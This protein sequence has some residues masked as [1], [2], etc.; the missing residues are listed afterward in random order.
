MQ[1]IY[2]VGVNDG[3][4]TAFYLSQGFRVVGI[5]ANPL[6]AKDLK[7]RFSASI[8]DGSF[9][10]LEIG[11]GRE[12]GEFEFWVCDD[13]S[14][15]S[16]F[17][18]EIASRN[19]ARHHGVVVKTRRFRDV[20]AEHGRAFYCKIDIEGNDRTC[21]ENLP[22]ALAPHYL[23]IEMAHADGIVDL[24][25]LRGLS[26]TRF[27]IISQSSFAQPDRRLS[28]LAFSLPPSARNKFLRIEKALRGVQ[29]QD[30]WEFPYGSSGPFGERTPGRW[31]NFD[32]AAAMWRF[33]HDLD[34]TSGTR[35]IGDWYD[36]HA[37]R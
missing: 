2:D 26:Y 6:L 33:L 27:K 3:A 21:I 37:A 14:D 7:T 11:I 32:E 4:D 8:E 25:L 35:G 34:A 29:R 22:P 24:E 28:A 5:E 30:E 15:W 9:T 17:D 1:T 19:G 13:H 31:K 36:I 16:S 18:R 12:E 20:V 10:L 23:S